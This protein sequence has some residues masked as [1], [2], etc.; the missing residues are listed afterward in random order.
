MDSELVQQLL[1]YFKFSIEEI[2]TISILFVL[3]LLQIY[4]YIKVY[5]KPYTYVCANLENDEISERKVLPKVS[6]II[7]SENEV[8]NLAENLPIILEQDY[9]DFEVIVVNDG[10]TDE[11]DTLLKA[12]CGKYPNLYQTFLPLSTDRKFARHKLALTVGIKAAKGDVLLF[13]EPYCCPESDQWIKCMANKFSDKTEVVLGYSY[14]EKT[15]N[16]ANRIARFDNLLFSMHYLSRAIK[17]R[18]YVGVY[19]NVAFK[20]ELF[21]E[22]KGFASFLNVENGED[23]FINQIVNRTN[24]EVALEQNSF[25]RT[26]INS[27]A[28][29]RLIKKNYSVARPL[30]KKGAR[31]TFKNEAITR[32]LFYILFIAL[33]VYSVFMQNWALMGITILFFFIRL[34]VQLNVMKKISTYFNGGKFYFSLIIMDLLQPIYNNHFKTRAKKVSGRK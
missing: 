19:R 23:V 17:E 26:K 27:Y 28:M 12:L 18:P 21:F 15:K 9:P 22:N 31:G 8:D 13:T 4:F 32:Y 25:V 3:L 11:S 30:F 1:S 33:M 10:S 20:K 5:R 7:S 16:F 34:A 6:V 14:F 24:T 2:V 29:W